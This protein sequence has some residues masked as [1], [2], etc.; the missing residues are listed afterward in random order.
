MLDCVP[1]PV[2]QMTSGNSAFRSSF[3][4]S[5]SSQACSMAAASFPSRSP[6]AW[7][8][9]AQAFFRMAKAWITGLGICSASQF[10]LAPM[11]KL[12]R[13]RCVWAPKRRS[14]GT[15]TT[16]MVSFSS[17]KDDIARYTL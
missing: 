11:R 5:T 3:S 15:F 4:A 6:L 8:T 17:R 1:L 9:R 7:L 14:A 16:P 2:C 12:S 13:E 10:W